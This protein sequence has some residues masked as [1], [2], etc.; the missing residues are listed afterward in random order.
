MPLNGSSGWRDAHFES[1][2]EDYCSDWLNRMEG[3]E[4]K[5]KKIQDRI[6]ERYNKND[7]KNWVPDV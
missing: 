5:C 3:T 1:E 2:L 6:E 4:I 7:W